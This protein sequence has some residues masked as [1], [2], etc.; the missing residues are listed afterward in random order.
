MSILPL[1]SVYWGDLFLLELPCI[2]L[3]KTS[4]TIEQIIWSFVRT[5][6]ITTCSIGDL[7][8]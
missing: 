4:V 2:M 6:P 8:P 1:R 5:S 3:M 7:G